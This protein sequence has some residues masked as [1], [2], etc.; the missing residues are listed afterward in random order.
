[1][2]R[3]LRFTS[4][5]RPLGRWLV[6]GDWE[7]RAELATQDACGSDL[8]RNVPPI[9]TQVQYIVLNGEVH[10]ISM[11]LVTQARTLPHLPLN[12]APVERN[13]S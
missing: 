6:S 10:G 12:A 11:Q 5:R 8:C 3:F 7:R 2:L 4:V 1:M 13:V 9:A